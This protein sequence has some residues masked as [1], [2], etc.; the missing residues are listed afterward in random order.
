MDCHDSNTFIT[1]GRKKE[2][3]KEK[4]IVV[5]LLSGISEYLGWSVIKY[6]FLIKFLK[7]IQKYQ[8]WVHFPPC[9]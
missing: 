4:K 2:K 5:L 1:Q 7:S 8:I 6:S 3:E 9:F